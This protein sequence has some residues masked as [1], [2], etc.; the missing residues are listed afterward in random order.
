L[1]QEVST[2][3]VNRHIADFIEDSRS[4]PVIRICAIKTGSAFC[5]R[6]WDVYLLE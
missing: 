2:G 3:L 4:F 5:C 6:P 1:E